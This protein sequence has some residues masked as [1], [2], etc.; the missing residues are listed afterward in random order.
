MK[1]LIH[2]F[3]LTS[4]LCW[5]LS[6]IAT[7]FSDKIS[8]IESTDESSSLITSIFMEGSNSTSYIQKTFQLFIPILQMGAA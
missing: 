3:R 8:E 4:T 7:R 1:Y 2:I 5:H 6:G